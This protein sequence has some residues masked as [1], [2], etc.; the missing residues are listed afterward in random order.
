[1]ASKRPSSSRDDTPAGTESGGATSTHVDAR[2]SHADVEHP[3]AQEQYGERTPEAILAE[4]RTAAENASE[5]LRPDGAWTASVTTAIARSGIQV[6]ARATAFEVAG[7]RVEIVE[8]LGPGRADAWVRI[9]RWRGDG[10]RILADRA[11]LHVT[12]MEHADVRVESVDLGRLRAFRSTLDD[13]KHPTFA[14]LHRGLFVRIGATDQ[15]RATALHKALDEIGAYGTPDATPQAAP[16]PASA[17]EA[18][19][20]QQP[21]TPVEDPVVGQW[22]VR[23][24]FILSVRG[25]G[26]WDMQR[27][28]EEASVSSGT[29][30]PALLGTY[31]FATGKRDPEP[32][33]ASIGRDGTLLLTDGGERIEAR[34]DQPRKTSTFGLPAEGGDGKTGDMPFEESF[35]ETEGLSDAPF[36]GPANNGTIGSRRRR[37]GAFKGR[38]AE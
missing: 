30:R 3:Q 16:A 10:D 4:V 13:P 23:E 31:T 28:G 11:A 9:E 1:M 26:T 29:W 22:I 12:P 17:P 18:G 6:A 14:W 21:T 34:R 24:A 32:A 5:P 36:E 37:G 8:A 25:D 19:S 7:G 2:D 15:A 33:T 35:G 38:G 27:R 20:P